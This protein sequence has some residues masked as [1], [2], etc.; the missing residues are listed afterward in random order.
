[1]AV[2]TKH[3]AST[4][5]QPATPPDGTSLEER[6]NAFV[7]TLNQKDILDILFDFSSTGKYGASKEYIA[8]VVYVG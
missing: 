3:F 5:Q 8:Q 2:K 1:M 7:A 4:L 6:V